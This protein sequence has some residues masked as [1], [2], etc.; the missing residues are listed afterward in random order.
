MSAATATPRFINGNE[1]AEI[2][3][4]SPATV[5]T[6]RCREPE[7]LPPHYRFG[8]AIRYRLDEV[9]SWA[10]ERRQEPKAAATSHV[11]QA[12]A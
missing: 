10:E 5:T 3:G 8:S 2:L 1:L 9:L 11:L 12:G 6:R 4:L 7:N